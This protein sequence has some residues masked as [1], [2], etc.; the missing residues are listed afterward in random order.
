[1]S[2]NFGKKV[3]QGNWVVLVCVA[4]GAY[5]HF[6]AACFDLVLFGRHLRSLLQ[7]M[8]RCANRGIFPLLDCLLVGCKER[9]R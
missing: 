9:E 8:L 1:M 4:A 6:A 5:F 7:V 3:R 2:R